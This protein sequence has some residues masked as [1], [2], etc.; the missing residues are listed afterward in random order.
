[1][2]KKRVPDILVE[3]LLLGEL[4]EGKSRE[5]LAD[6]EV[7]TRMQELQASN[8]EILERY[9]P[10]V[11]SRRIWWRV[12]KEAAAREERGRRRWS[13]PRLAPA[14]AFAALLVAVGVVLATVAPWKTLDSGTRLKGVRPH[15]VIYRKT[16]AGAEALGPGSP[17]RGGDV[18]Q[19]GYV[20]AAK[21]F[22]V[23]FSIDGSGVLTLHYPPSETDTGG[24]ATRLQGEG[25]VL[26]DFS[27][28]LDN[29]PG[30]ERFFLVTSAREPALA[31]VLQ[32]GRRLAT[33]PKQARKASLALPAGLEQWSML[34]TKD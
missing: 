17:V 26:L 11:M 14:A 3:Q 27:Y 25:E 1:M 31:E 30:F 12:E 22:G 33:D 28:Q 2:S 16:A 10:E 13:L 34:L 8:R 32:A 21:P 9:P 5:L 29:A 18:L 19:I 7:R 23:I 24:A 6:P 15:L 4:P 20:S